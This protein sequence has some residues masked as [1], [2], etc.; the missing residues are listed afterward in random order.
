MSTIPKKFYHGDSQP[1]ARTVGQLKKILAE[2]PNDLPPEAG[3]G[4]AV[5]AVVYNH[6]KDDMHLELQEFE[7]ED[8]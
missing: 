3:F 7:D 6:G 8:E 4:A 1:C 2:L 5:Q